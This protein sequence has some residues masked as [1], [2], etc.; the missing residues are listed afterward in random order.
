[1][2]ILPD[3]S[4]GRSTR[5]KEMVVKPS[6]LASR[7]SICHWATAWDLDPKLKFLRSRPDC[8]VD[9]WDS[10]SLVRVFSCAVRVYT[11]T[12]SVFLLLFL[13]DGSIERFLIG[14]KQAASVYDASIKKLLRPLASEEQTR[15]L[16]KSSDKWTGWVRSFLLRED[17]I[18][19]E[20]LGWL[21]KL[22]GKCTLGKGNPP[23]EGCSAYIPRITCSRVSLSL[24]A[25][26]SIQF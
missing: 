25:T 26:H 19:L 8:L 13:V 20:D 21:S 24:L 23:N 14:L 4:T 12:L 17:A 3:R 7:L 6:V 2:N 15:G 16:L 18:L 1:M 11:L 9:I 10:I 5:D 22:L